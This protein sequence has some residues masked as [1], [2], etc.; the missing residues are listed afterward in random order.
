MSEVSSPPTIVIDKLVVELTIAQ[1]AASKIDLKVVPQPGPQPRHCEL[2]GMVGF[3]SE[4]MRGSLMIASTFELFARSRLAAVKSQP[5]SPANARDWLYVRDW[6]TELTNQLAGRLKN[7]LVSFGVSLRASTAT[8]L[9]GSAL[10]FGTPTAS[11]AKPHV[12][13]A[14]S[15]ELWVFFDAVIEPDMQLTPRSEAAAEEGEV[16][17]F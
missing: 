5:L 14:G 1:L 15:E 2:A 3:T 7:R 10:A 9:S 4:R 16:I 17:L 6:A 13:K 12:F 11:R 8:A